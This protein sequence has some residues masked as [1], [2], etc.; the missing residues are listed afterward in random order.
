MNNKQVE[1]IIALYIATGKIVA[2][3][4]LAIILFVGGMVAAEASN[5]AP[6]DGVC[7]VLVIEDG[8]TTVTEVGPC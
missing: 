7:E 6:K 2:V 4:L 1:R 5:S 3:V 8:Q